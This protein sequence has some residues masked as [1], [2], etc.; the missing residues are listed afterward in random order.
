MDES[1][2]EPMAAGVV[3]GAFR[4]YG[5]TRGVCPMGGDGRRWAAVVDRLGLLGRSL[6]RWIVVEW[7][8]RAV[9]REV[10]AGSCRCRRR[11]VASERGPGCGC[12]REECLMDARWWWV[13]NVEA[14]RRSWNMEF[15]HK[16][17]PAANW[18]GVLLHCSRRD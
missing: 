7:S 9:G 13:W 15:E 8:G 4:R 6:V 10:V 11:A 16:L 5:E 17:G 18:G 14:D 1:T 12:E 2:G 3:E